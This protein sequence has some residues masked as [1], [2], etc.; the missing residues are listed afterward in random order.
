MLTSILVSRAG[1]SQAV[2]NM[3]SRLSAPQSLLPVPS[4]TDFRRGESIVYVRKAERAGALSHGDPPTPALSAE[5]N[6]RS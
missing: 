4:A 2:A 6:E 3:H 1:A 5:K